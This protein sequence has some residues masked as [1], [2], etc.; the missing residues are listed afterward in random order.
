MFS[1]NVDNSCSLINS[2][3]SCN[4]GTCQTNKDKSQP[5]Q[6]V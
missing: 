3:G 1:V 2:K 5:P 6:C 4:N